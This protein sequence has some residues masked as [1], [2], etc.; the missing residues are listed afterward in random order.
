MLALRISAVLVCVGLISGYVS[1]RDSIPN[2]RNVPHPCVSGE[3]WQGVG[4][5]NPAGGGDRNQFGIDFASQGRTWANVCN[6]DSDGDGMTNGQELGDPQCIWTTGATPARTTELTH[7]GFCDT[8]SSQTCA[9]LI[10]APCTSSK[11]NCTGTTETGVQK[12]TLKIPRTPVPGKE[13]TYVC[14]TFDL[15]QSQDYH[16]IA[17]E[18]EID[19]VDIMH[20]ILL[21]GCRDYAPKIE[22]PEEC[23]MSSPA[24]QDVI[25]LWSFGMF[26][27]CLYKEAGF[28]IGKTGYK[29]VLLEFHWNNPLKATGKM[30]GSGLNLYYTP[31]LRTHDAGVFWTGDTNIVIPPGRSRT[32]LESMCPA[33]CTNKILKDTIY[34]ISGINHMHYKGIAQT[35]ELFSG[36][37]KR[38]LTND[39]NYNYD[40]P[41]SVSYDPPVPIHRGDSLK[42]TCVYQSLSTKT[43]TFY[44][45]A[46]SNEMCFGIFIYYPKQASSNSNCVTYKTLN[47]CDIEKGALMGCNIAE[48]FNNSHPVTKMVMD[49]VLDNC[50]PYYGCREEC[51]AAIAEAERHPC[52]AKGDVQNYLLTMRSRNP[53]LKTTKFVAAF[54]SCSCKK[55]DNGK[56][57]ISTA[58]A[59][60]ADAL[61]ST[62]VLAF[63]SVLLL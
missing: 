1:Y 61:V 46:T 40:D 38:Y 63:C 24:C 17:T 42:T 51:P 14:M 8:S 6:M 58:G 10:T 16:L 39:L 59:T 60:S 55:D 50:S 27:Q 44:G 11:F 31:N 3:M 7:P 19:N 43:T 26:G 15:D 37:Q 36:D 33:R 49:K 22:S 5:S 29:R 56:Y 9:G 13:T 12:R 41:T 35:V 21:Y 57:P 4:H 54:G 30:D 34:M 32:V 53:D 52:L 20:H 48:F 45:D 25:G 62:V 47:R 23:G 18:P 28:R 2:G